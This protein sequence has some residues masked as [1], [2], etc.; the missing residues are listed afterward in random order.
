ML[1]EVAD[2]SRRETL[3]RLGG[4]E[5][6][7]YRLGSAQQVIW[8]PPDDSPETLPISRSQQRSAERLAT[9]VGGLLSV[10]YIRQAYGPGHYLIVTKKQHPYL[11]SDDD[12]FYVISHTHRVVE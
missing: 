3:R 11:H 9:W 2:G 4:A 12:P 6:T 10:E 7:L 8:T 5:Q 1:A